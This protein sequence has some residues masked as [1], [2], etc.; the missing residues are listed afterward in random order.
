MPQVSQTK[1]MIWPVRGLLMSLM[2]L[3]ELM[4]LMGLIEN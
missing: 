3:M 4:G 2:G 1:V